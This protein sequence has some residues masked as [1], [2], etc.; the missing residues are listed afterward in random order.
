MRRNRDLDSFG[1][2]TSDG[3]SEY[4]KQTKVVAVLDG[5]GRTEGGVEVESDEGEEDVEVLEG[6]GGVPGS[7]DDGDG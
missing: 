4:K 7:V 6:A 1:I 2:S 3:G 5:D